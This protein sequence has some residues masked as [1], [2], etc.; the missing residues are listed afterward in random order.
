MM[1]WEYSLRISQS[2]A[3]ICYYTGYNALSVSH[4]QTV[5]S[6][7]NNEV[8]VEQGKKAA[9]FYNYTGDGAEIS[10]WS[11]IKI[12]IGKRIYNNKADSVDGGDINQSEV[13][14]IYNNLYN[15]IADLNNK[16]EGI[17]IESRINSI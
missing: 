9:L 2:K 7:K 17:F 11:K 6:L 14:A 12:F 4:P 8:I 3:N 5:S 1:D 13:P 16:E 10:L 15:Y